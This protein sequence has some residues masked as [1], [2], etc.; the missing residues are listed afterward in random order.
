MGSSEQ[1]FE[2]W[3]VLDKLISFQVVVGKCNP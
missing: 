2:K 1:E 3:Q